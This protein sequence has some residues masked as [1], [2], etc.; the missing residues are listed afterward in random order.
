MATEYLFF[1]LTLENVNGSSKN[2]TKVLTLPLADAEDLDFAKETRRSK[3]IEL[4]EFDQKHLGNKN[5]TLKLHLSTKLATSLPVNFC[6]D[7]SPL[8]KEVGLICAA[9]ILGGLY[10]L[11]IWELIHRTFAAIIASTLS[12]GKLAVFFVPKIFN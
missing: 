11:I 2:L 4:E 9:L 6:Y 5:A 3:T 1:Y 7:P 12:I 10:V 8:N